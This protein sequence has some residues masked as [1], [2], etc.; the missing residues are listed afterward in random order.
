MLLTAYSISILGMIV[1][2]IVLVIYLKRKFNLPW[3]LPVAGAVTFILS[4]VLHIPFL[5]GL[6][7]LFQNGSLPKPP[8]SWAVLFNATLLGLLAGIFEETARYIL[9]KFV[10]KQAK[11][12]RDGV[13][14]GAGHGGIEASLLGLLGIATVVNMVVMRNATDLSVFNIPASQV[15]AVK[16][17]IAAFWSAPVYMAFLGLIERAF[18]IC[19]HLSLSVMVLYSVAHKKPIWFWVALLW[20]AVVDG[21]AV[22][23]LPSLGAV[24]VEAV[25]GVLAVISLVIL[26]RMEPLFSH[27]EP[28]VQDLQPSNLE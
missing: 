26:F 2:P 20:H 7:A 8:A 14:V 6:T 28:Q 18:A 24:G 21:A 11:T 12:W 16:Q 5:Y 10:L 22:F 23:L 27:E 3:K 13:L 4:Q 17:Q 25:V 9:F 1:L 15:G 19:L